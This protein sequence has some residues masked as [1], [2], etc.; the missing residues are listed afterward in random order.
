MH[1]IIEKKKIVVLLSKFNTYISKSLK[2]PI[3]SNILLI[4]NINKLIFIVTNLDMEINYSIIL[5]NGEYFKDG[6]ITVNLNRFY[7][8]CNS[9]PK[10]SIIDINYYKSKLIIS[11]LNSISSL[12]T[13]PVNDFPILDKNIFFSYNFYINSFI[14]K[15]IIYNLYLF[16]GN[17]DI[18]YY[19]N[20]ML[21]EFNNNFL[22]FVT[23]DGYRISIYKLLDNF[24]Y[25]KNI[26]FCLIIP[27]KLV[28]ELFKL[29][30]L[31][32]DK[33]IFFYVNK[34][35]IKIIYGNIVIYSSLIDGSFPDYKNILHLSKKYIYIDINS[36]N[37]KDA[38]IRCSIINNNLSSYVTLIFYNNFLLV[39][40][41][42]FNNNKIKEKIFIN[43]N[44]NKIKISFNIKY[45]LDIF[46][47][48]KDNLNIR[49]YIKDS[50]SITKIVDIN[51]IFLTYM[52][53]PVQL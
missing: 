39:Y 34:N 22:Y 35:M 24:V 3:L 48:I 2:N 19:L 14:F 41:N 18:Y 10:G 53:M 47:S 40:S 29:L 21:I 33:N 17:Q 15:N 30:D 36:K 37:L 28:I 11:C 52:V 32:N 9:F 4:L 46:K 6:S 20:G 25:K 44:G 51:N 8:L 31:I 45:I 16:M 13:L 50:L 42:D 23:T 1:F 49:F 7:E 5:S 43:Y 26:F 12:S 38:L 27:R